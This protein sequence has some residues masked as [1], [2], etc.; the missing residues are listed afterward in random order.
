MESTTP[1]VAIPVGDAG[2]AGAVG[3]DPD[4]DRRIVARVKKGNP[5]LG[6]GCLAVLIVVIAVAGFAILGN[7]GKNTTA[8]TPPTTTGIASSAPAISKAAPKTAESSAA[9][10]CPPTRDVY[11][12]YVDP[13]LPASA[14]D[15]GNY[16]V[17][18]CETTFDSLEATSPME[19]GYCTTAAWAS[20]NPGY[21]V[22]A[23]P[24]APLQDI[25]V[26][27]G[28]AC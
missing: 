18:T 3:L 24:A 10:N 14:S 15:L 12:R 11:V 6:C 16:D 13:G 20:N 17:L 26:A 19:A 9:R 27:V 2:L 1:L 25:E 22:N 8:S 28:P 21:N 4:A 7:S 23:T 5:A